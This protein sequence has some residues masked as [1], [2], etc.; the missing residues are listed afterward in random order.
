MPFVI[1][2]TRHDIAPKGWQAKDIASYFNLPED[3]VVPINAENRESVR[4][5]VVC[6]MKQVE[7]A[8]SAA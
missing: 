7:S 6:L 2:S 8:V 5:A 1:A 3:Q 4:S